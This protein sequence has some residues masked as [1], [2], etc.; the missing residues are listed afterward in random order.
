MPKLTEEQKHQKY[1]RTLQTRKWLDDERKKREKSDHRHVW[2]GQPKHR[3]IGYFSVTCGVEGC[4][5]IK[6][7]YGKAGDYLC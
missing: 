2:K 6:A 4:D 3:F 7:F 1:L 5:A